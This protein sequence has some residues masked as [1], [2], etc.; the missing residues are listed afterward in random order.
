MRLVEITPATWP[1]FEELFGPGGIQ[2]GCWCSYFRLSSRDFTAAGAAGRRRV[3]LDDVE[4]GEPFGL[5]A[6]DADDPVGW[7]SV[8]PKGCF[9]RLQ[10]SPIARPE[11]GYEPGDTWSVVCFYVPR[12]ARGRGLASTLLDGAVASAARHGAA[13]VEGYPV[14][15]TDRRVPVSDLY[16]GS[17]HTFLRGGFTLIERRGTSR[18]LVRRQIQVVAEPSP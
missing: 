14:D 5:V 8:S 4:R 9:D 18:A 6:M 15:T 16:Y 13:A 17:L 7:V 10:R 1:V 2:G 11:Q 12:H 3:V